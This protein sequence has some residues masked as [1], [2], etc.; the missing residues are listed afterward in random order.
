MTSGHS[1]LKAFF[2]RAA[3]YHVVSRWTVKASADEVAGIFRDVPSLPRWWPAVFLDAEVLRPGGP[4]EI[5]LRTRLHTKGWLP[6]T[7]RLN[8]TIV[9][10]ADD[11]GFVLEVDGDLEGGCVCTASRRGDV[12]DLVFDWRVRAIKLL[13]RTLSPILKRVFVQN[14]MWVMARGQE[15]LVLEIVRRRARRLGI[16]TG[17]PAPQGPTF[18]YTRPLRPL[19]EWLDAERG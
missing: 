2:D 7:L 13:V 10:T 17:V 19:M 16:S 6:Y 15:S 9:S 12:V 3:D 11:G 8:F 14:H 1:R 5:G 4:G 18:P